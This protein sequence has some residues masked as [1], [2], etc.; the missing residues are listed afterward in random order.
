MIGTDGRLAT[1]SGVTLTGLSIKQFAPFWV[2]AT[3]VFN[4]RSTRSPRG[5]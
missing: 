1:T 2:N 5:P 3:G 4:A